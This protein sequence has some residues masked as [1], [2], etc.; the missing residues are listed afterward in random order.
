MTMRYLALACDF[1]DTLVRNGELRPE[2]VSA[3]EKLRASGRK[4]ILVTGREFE[5]LL[6]VCP[7]IGLFDRVVAEN[8]ALIYWPESKKEK[9]LADAPPPALINALRE[10]SVPFSQGR[11]VA[12][13]GRP[14]DT[15][16]LQAIS[17]LGL[18]HQIIFNK[19]SAMVLPSGTNKA[20]GLNAA[21]RDIKL[22][23]HN[24]VGIGDAENDHAF[25]NLCECAVAV[26]NALP[27]VQQRADF[28]TS[29]ENGAGV[30]ELIEELVAT[31]LAAREPLLT[32]HHIPIGARDGS[33]IKI[34]AYSKN[35]LF[36]GSSGGGKS[37]LAT[38]FLERLLDARYQ[39]CVIDPEGDY[40]SFEGAVVLGNKERAPDPEEVLKVLEDPEDNLVINLIGVDLAGRPEYLLALLPRL[41][42]MRAQTGR[43]HWILLDETHHVLPSSWN[44]ATLTLPQNQDRTIFVTV[45]PE[46]VHSIALETVE[47]V[48]TVGDKPWKTLE[49]FCGAAGVNSPSGGD[50][51]LKPGEALFWSRKAGGEPFVF[52][53]NPNRTQRRRHRRKYAEGELPEERSFYFRGA[54]GN[55]NLRAQN[56]ILFNQ[57]GQGVDDETWLH[58]LRQG[59]YSR[60]FREKIKDEGLADEAVAVESMPDISA[61][62]SR[63]MI[64]HMIGKR[65]THPE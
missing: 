21:L 17:D 44:P 36:A 41:Q 28:V 22:S 54:G 35:L 1:D 59:D 42:E 26:A 61:A 24:V 27:T 47:T 2:T 52:T 15:A 18:E 39:F 46:Q 31:D 10:R 58:H 7:S 8:G 14:Y 16:M 23:P 63:R 55:L 20:T 53:V 25:L 65:Y 30:I 33:E 51:I 5:D 62:E 49:R 45:D 13:T 38:A 32:R 50:G 43:P 19:G 12:S 64:K 60:W 37:T 3:L 6:S 11:V 4:A 29:D 9:L 40:E 48:I 56:L 57:I 34:P